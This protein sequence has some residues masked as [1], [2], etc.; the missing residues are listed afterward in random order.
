MS[1]C[2]EEGSEEGVGRERERGEEEGG[3]GREEE[4][5]GVKEGEGEGVR[6]EVVSDEREVNMSQ[7]E[8]R[9]EVN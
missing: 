6:R 2:K 9:E 8:R 7:E 3:K 1:V 4:R 5:G